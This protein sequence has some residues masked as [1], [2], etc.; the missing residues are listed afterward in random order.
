MID[1]LEKAKD[2]L[3]AP[4]EHSD[5][6]RGP[7]SQ[8]LAAEKKKA[9][10]SGDENLGKHV[11]CLEQVLDIQ[12][13]YLK[14]FQQIKGGNY[15]SGWLSLERAEIA[16][17]FLRPHFAESF[18]EYQL[19]FIEDQVPRWQGIYP[20]KYFIS[21]EILEHE[22][23]CTICDQP[24]SIRSPCGHRVGEV[25]NGELCLRRVTKADF[26][27]MAIAVEKPVQKYSVV[28][29]KDSEISKHR[30]HYNYNIV[31]FVAERLRGPFDSWSYTWTKKRHPHERYAHIGPSKPC[32]CESGRVYQE[33][34]FHEPGV[35]R[36][37]LDVRFSIP[38]P[39][40][41]PTLEYAP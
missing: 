8:F 25:Y 10:Q 12:N 27:G 15:Y 34:C 2:I 1:S 28:F 4:G 13:N 14:A 41:L 32:P 31:R 23:R 21:P 5:D 6:L 39:D 36:P 24:V 16:L 20:Y 40:D 35:L 17:G 38:P 29:L 22:K 26:L 7:V 11:W 19:N 9:V 18:S 30:D 37:H 33:C 3:R